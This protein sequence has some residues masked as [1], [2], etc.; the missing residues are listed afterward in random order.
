MGVVVF[1]MVVHST[2]KWFTAIGFCNADGPG[3]PMEA[4]HFH[5][6]R[7]AGGAFPM[8]TSI[9]AVQ[10]AGRAIVTR[11]YGG[12]DGKSLRIEPDR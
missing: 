8:Q 6:P 7:H 5:T 3:R 4:P 12:I 9:E 10:V 11:A 1:R 2:E